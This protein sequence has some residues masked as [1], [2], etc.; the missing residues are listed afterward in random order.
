MRRL[1]GVTWP[2][3]IPTLEALPAKPDKLR[4]GLPP[5]FGETPQWV[6]EQGDLVGRGAVLATSQHVDHH[7]A[8]AGRI[9]SLTFRTV[10][11]ATTPEASSPPPHS[12]T[13][14]GSY[15]D[16]LKRI[17]LV[18][19]GGSMFPTARKVAVSESYHTLVINGVEC[20][21]G[22]TIDQSILLHASDTIRAAVDLAVEK[23]GARRVILAVGRHRSRMAELRKRYP[24]DLL[25]MARTYPAGAERL[26]M[27]RLLKR[28]PATGEL[29]MQ[30]GYLVQNVASLWAVGQ[31]VTTGYPVLERPLSL[32]APEA[33]IYHNWRVPLGTAVQHL[34]D[35]AHIPY[36]PEQHLLIGGGLMMGR[37]ITPEMNIN[38]G[39]TSVLVI[40]RQG[41]ES[42]ARDCI[43][44]GA[45]NAA[46]P[47]GLHPIGIV[48]RAAKRKQPR[49]A[50]RTQL[51]ACF[52]C[53]A[54]EA[55]CPSD[56]RL[57]KHL[58]EAKQWI[59]T[60]PQS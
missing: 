13:C 43:R 51:D 34:L 40:P 15:S 27:R 46:C 41:L 37:A 35:T 49:T 30:S 50:L 56:I 6:I 23:T 39:T 48:D 53:G 42:P 26:I 20:E 59:K 10:T 44:C 7:A 38:Q 14:D 19:M 1:I 52:L 36:D 5:R 55:V 2:D 18:G 47:L 29:P 31:A 22:I 21:P 32:A 24:Y 17:G 57:I 9:D 25:P 33:D 3:H 28:M 4:V 60:H 11:I 54:C 12:I 45:C 58:K 8:L 16:I